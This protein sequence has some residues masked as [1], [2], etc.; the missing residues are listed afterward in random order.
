M[1]PPFA[2]FA[3]RKF[4]GPESPDGRQPFALA[5]K[6]SDEMIVPGEGFSKGEALRSLTDQMLQVN[7]YYVM[8]D[9]WWN[10]P[11][12]HSLMITVR[13]ELLD[14]IGRR[15]GDWEVWGIL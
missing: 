13:N 4:L 8:H 12:R 10:N 15:I 7:L 11:I 1:T 6:A 9:A 3:G 14:E 2:G 5:A